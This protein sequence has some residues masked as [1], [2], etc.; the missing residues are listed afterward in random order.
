MSTYL[1]IHTYTQIRI[2]KVLSVVVGHGRSWPDRNSLWAPAGATARKDQVIEQS[3]GSGVPA[4]E[5]GRTGDLKGRQ[6]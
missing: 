3:D 2:F 4:A 6:V 5:R 1:Y